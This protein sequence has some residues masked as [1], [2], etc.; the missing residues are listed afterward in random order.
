MLFLFH[1]SLPHRACRVSTY[2][3]ILG[4]FVFVVD[5]HQEFGELL[6]KIDLL[7]RKCTRTF[8]SSP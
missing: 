8:L 2:V 6:Q 1:L 5:D 4:I 7:C 3:A